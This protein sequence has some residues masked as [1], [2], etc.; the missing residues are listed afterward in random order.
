MHIGKLQLTVLQG[1]SLA[2][3]RRIVE[4][5]CGRDENIRDPRWWKQPTSFQGENANPFHLDHQNGR[6]SKVTSNHSL[7]RPVGSVR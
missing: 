7:N 4:G 6:N 1:K 5:L 2:D 3:R